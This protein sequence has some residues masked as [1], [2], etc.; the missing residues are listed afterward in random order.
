MQH[1]HGDGDGGPPKPPTEPVGHSHGHSHSHG[2]GHGHG[3]EGGWDQWLSV[4]ALRL[5]LTAV[6]VAGLLTVVGIVVLWPNGEGRQA[7]IDEAEALGLATEQFDATVDSVRDGPCS[8]DVA[9][10]CREFSFQVHEGPDAGGLVLLPEYNL[11]V[12]APAPTL[13]VND[14][15]FLGYEPRTAFY[16]YA[17]Q[18]RGGT[19]ILL[20]ALFAVVVVALGRVRGLLAL[21]A[22]VFTV[23]TLIGFV[24]PAVLD[25]RDPI[26]VAVVAGSAIAFAGLY[27][28]HGFNPTTTVALAGTLASLLL[29]LAVS[30]VFFRLARFSGLATEEGLTLPLLADG[31]NLSS[32]LLGGAVI[33]ALGALDD[34]TVTQVATVAELKLRN[35]GLTKAELITS[36]IRVGREH[37]ASTVNTLLLAY[38]GA[39]MPLLLIFAAANQPLGT[40]ANSEI[41]AV[42]IV[43]TLTG[44][45]G[46]VAAVPI[47]TAMAALLVGSN[48]GAQAVA[49]D[50]PKPERGP[51]H[52]SGGGNPASRTDRPERPTSPPVQPAAPVA[53]DV[54]I[55]EDQDLPVDWSAAGW[56]QFA[57]DEDLDLS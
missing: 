20:T 50:A 26:A 52:G 16:F 2:H 35:Q 25:G 49:T 39:S 43:R 19:L 46:L 31:V 12:G 40:V 7:A 21:A 29:T 37:I 53:A 23:I 1:V 27:L 22:M 14:S 4:P 13:S 17:D 47:T 36:G 24:A 3:L 30:A 38:A 57:P 48:A 45:I 18:D 15:V 44:S 10:T 51:D 33:G 8:Y 41:V 5:I 54:D 9:Q 32:L 42:E 56:D 34:V 55:A 28:T 6:I 11:S